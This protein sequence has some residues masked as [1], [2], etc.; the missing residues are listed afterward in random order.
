MALRPDEITE[1]LEKEL[2]DYEGTLEVDDVGTILRLGDNIA[3]VYGLR[4]A[5]AGE[6]LEFPG[7]VVGM[8]LNLEESSV[9]VALFGSDVGISEGDPVKRTGR[10]SAVPVGAARLGRAGPSPEGVERG[11]ARGRRGAPRA[12]GGAPRRAPTQAGGPEGRRPGGWQRTGQPR[13]GGRRDPPTPR[14]VPVSFSR[15]I[16][17]TARL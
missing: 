14:R 16:P 17:T 12:G 15:W 8:V 11:R 7:G 1:I 6:L 4:S 9:G 2:A 10:I 5:M 3:T 13:G